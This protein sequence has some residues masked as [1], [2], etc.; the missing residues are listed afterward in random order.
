MFFQVHRTLY[1][2]PSYDKYWYK[3]AT[4]RSKSGEKMENVRNNIKNLNY[5][6]LIGKFYSDL[7]L[8]DF[9]IENHF[10]IDTNLKTRNRELLSLTSNIINTIHWTDYDVQLGSTHPKDWQ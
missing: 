2:N 1:N 9:D 8:R 5:E 7:A 10:I 3:N 4:E 6:D